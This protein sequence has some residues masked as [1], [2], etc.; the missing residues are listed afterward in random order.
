MISVVIIAKNEAHIIGQILQSLQGISDDI[1]V[2]DNGSTDG[3]QSICK[4]YSARLIETSWQGYGPTKNIGIDAATHD[5]I[6]NLDADEAV[7]ADLKTVIQNLPLQNENEAFEMRFK[8][9][10]LGK[11]IRH[12]EWGS[13]K[14]IR[15]FNRNKIRWNDAAVHESLTISAQTIVTLLNGYI[16]HYTTH[17]LEEYE[18]KTVAYAKLNA[19]KYFRQGK[20]SSF[21]K[22]YIS[23]IFSFIHNYIIRLGF[24]DGKEGFMI[25]KT[26]AYYTYLKY[27][28]LKKMQQQNPLD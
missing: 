5:W 6:L 16:L 9:F 8:N 14:H 25:A 17:S 1:I 26:T 15:L 2:V 4:E 20:K 24:L 27:S 3:T 18:Q 12:G 7:D 11:W 13:D 10:F 21:I 28:F 23:P 19:Q 22:R